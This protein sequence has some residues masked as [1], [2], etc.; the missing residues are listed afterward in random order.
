MQKYA[1]HFCSLFPIPRLWYAD[2]E[3]PRSDV[4][5]AASLGSSL[6][7]ACICI[8]TSCNHLD[9]GVA[10][11]TPL[12]SCDSTS[13]KDDILRIRHFVRPVSSSTWFYD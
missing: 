4:A 6:N 2:V 8:V 9:R 13:F 11:C 3:K 12:S 5:L 1:S 10:A 7:P